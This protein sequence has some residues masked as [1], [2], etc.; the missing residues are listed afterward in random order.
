MNQEGFHRANAIREGHESESAINDDKPALKRRQDVLK[1]E[2]DF[3]S[4]KAPHPFTEPEKALRFARKTL[5][6]LAACSIYTAIYVIITVTNS[7][8]NAAYKGNY[9][10]LGISA[11]LFLGINI[12]L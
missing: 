9:I 8:W 11:G 5:S 2:D 6:V 4:A 3:I 12:F 7:D 10:L 1:E